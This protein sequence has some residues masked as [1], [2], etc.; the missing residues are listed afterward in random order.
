M[1]FLK[2]IALQKLKTPAVAAQYSLWGWGSNSVGQ[3]NNSNSPL[4]PIE[5]ITDVSYEASGQFA[6]GVIKTDGTLWM[7]GPNSS[8][9]LGQGN[10]TNLSSPKQVGSLTSWIT[11]SAGSAGDA[12]TLGIARN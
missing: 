12:S 6:F 5:V 2:N 8:G 4:T 3:L 10:T 11:V 9:Q 7:W 1:P